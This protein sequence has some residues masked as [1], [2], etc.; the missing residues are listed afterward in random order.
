MLNRQLGKS[1]VKVGEIGLGTEHLKTASSKVIQSVVDLAVQEGINYFDLLFNM[2]GYLQ[3]FGIAFKPYRDQLVLA[4]HLGSSERNGQYFKTR[5]VLECEKI[6]NHAL[7]QLDTS[8]VDIANVHYV[9]DM[10]EYL[11]ISKKDGVLDLAERLKSQG[12]ARLIGIST[13]DV[14]VVQEV[15]KNGRFDSV[16][17][18]VNFANNA[19]PK[20]NEALAACARQGVAVVAMKPFAGGTMLMKNETVRISAI[21]KGGG[22]T[23]KFKIPQEMTTTRCLSYVLSQI[24][25]STVIP[26]VKNLQELKEITAYSNST[27]EQKDYSEIIAGFNEYTTGQCVYCNH[28]LP[29]PQKID[30]ALVT[31]LLDSAKTGKI[32]AEYDM[33]EAK[34][35]KCTKCGSCMTRCPFQVNVIGNMEKAEALFEKYCFS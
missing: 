30:V 21:R 22:K 16:T 23:V 18:H 31:R 13:H 4:T 1:G 17:F 33:L 14:Q 6:F 10:K 20:R 27:V 2:T 25:V 8:Y 7:K 34:A 35:S 11:E 9:K 3:N 28:C 29:C 24:G 15:S 32:P 19:L 5:N 12:K 26:G